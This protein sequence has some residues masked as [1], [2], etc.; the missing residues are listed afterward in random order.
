[1][2]KI[3]RFENRYDI[4]KIRMTKKIHNLCTIGQDWFT[5]N[6]EI[7]FIPNEIIPDYIEVDEMIQKFEG[8]ELVIEEL[9]SG[10]LNELKEYK[11]LYV[12]VVSKV[13]DAMHLPVEVIAEYKN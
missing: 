12:K 2:I 1:M 5:N 4:T 9:L 6:L 7:E 13:D 10:I 3:A 8:K 11:P